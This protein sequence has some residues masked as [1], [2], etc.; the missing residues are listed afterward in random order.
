MELLT[1]RRAVDKM[2]AKPE[3]NLVDWAG[4]YL[5]SSRRL[6]CIM[7]PRLAGQYSIK[8]AKEMASL[9]LQCISLNPKDRPKMPSVVEA[10]EGLQNLKDMAVSYGHW[11]ATPKSARVNG[12]SPNKGGHR[13][14]HSPVTPTKKA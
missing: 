3:Q 5:T 8:G 14:K 6:R 12:A 1:G 11:P 13:R 2:R 7:D 9:A 10:L 4:P